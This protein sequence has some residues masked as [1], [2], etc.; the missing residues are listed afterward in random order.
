MR[1]GILADCFD[2]IVKAKNIREGLPTEGWP[3]M[4]DFA[5]WGFAIAEA[6]GL[7]GK[8]FLN[9]YANKV[10][11]ESANIL[12]K[13]AIA[14]VLEIFVRRQINN[15]FSITPNSLLSS[16]NDVAESMGYNSQP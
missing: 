12:D 5:A 10:S 1:P 16:L 3:R 2:I 15:V 6:I 11:T 14:E 8:T 9:I 4:A 13:S 7:G